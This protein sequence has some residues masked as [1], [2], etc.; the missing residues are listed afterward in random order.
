MYP[1]GTSI[2]ETGQ[3]LLYVR[4]DNGYHMMRAFTPKELAARQGIPRAIE[5]SPFLSCRVALP[6]RPGGGTQTWFQYVEQ[7]PI[8]RDEKMTATFPS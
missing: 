7:A 1:E 2:D 4:A 3:H 6:E 8:D 5:N